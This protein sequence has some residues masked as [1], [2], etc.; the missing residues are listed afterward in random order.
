MD[1]NEKQELD[2]LNDEEIDTVGEILNISMGSAATSLST[3]LE[4]QVDITTPNVKVIKTKDFECKNLE[5]GIGIEIKYIEGLHGSNIMIMKKSDIRI[6]VNL[7][8]GESYEDDNDD[9][10][11]MHLSAVGE[12][13]NQM[14]GASCTALAQFLGKNINISTPTQFDPKNIKEKIKVYDDDENIV[15]VSFNFKVE[16]LI[17]SD[18]ITIFPVPFTKELVTNAINMGNTSDKKPT[19]LK[20]EVNRE[21]VERSDAEKVNNKIS[22]DT[23][24]VRENNNKKTSVQPLTFKSFD[25][26]SS[27]EDDNNKVNY[28]LIMGVE[29]E[30]TV[31]IG[32]TK[33]PV[34]DVLELRAGSIIELDKQAGDPVDVI[35]NGQL[36]ARGDVVVIEDNFGVRITEI[37]LNK[38]KI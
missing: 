4:K 33:K 28:S 3:L 2:Q 13:M 16:G 30:V 7:L 10:S 21:K 9:L 35:V 5:P 11:E 22:D 23:N 37:I 14:M 29:L 1:I 12:I 34:K 25:K 15:I 26:E 31:E 18:F 8:I 6:I 32:R 24:S 20:A 38:D 27:S 19:S 36:I 17:N